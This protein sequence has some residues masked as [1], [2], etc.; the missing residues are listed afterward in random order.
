M[1]VALSIEA[2]PHP[3][4]ADDGPNKSPRLKHSPQSKSRIVQVLYWRP[5]LADDPDIESLINDIQII[6]RAK[7]DSVNR[8]QDRLEYNERTRKDFQQNVIQEKNWSEF[9]TQQDDERLA[10]VSMHAGP[11]STQSKTLANKSAEETSAG[12]ITDPPPPTKKTIF[13]KIKDWKSKGKRNRQAKRASKRKASSGNPAPKIIEMETID[14]PMASPKF[15]PTAHHHRRGS[16]QRVAA[17][18]SSTPSSKLGKSPLSPLPAPITSRPIPP[19]IKDFDIIK[20]ISKGA[21]GSVF[22]AKKR[23]TGDYYAIKFLKKSDMITK[24]QVTNVK[25]ERMILMAQTDSPFVTKLYYTFQSKDYLYLVLEYLNGGDCS[26]LVKVLGSLSLSWARNYLAEVTAG[27][28]YLHEKN[29]IHRDLKPDNLLIDQNGHLKLTDFGLSRIGFLDR[30]LRDELCEDLAPTSPAPSRSGTPPQSPSG[31][32][33]SSSSMLP[34]SKSYKQ[35][36]FSLLFDRDR[37]RRGSLASSGSGGDSSISSILN[38]EDEPKSSTGRKRTSSG[39]VAS[40]LTTPG[41]VHSDRVCSNDKVG[42]AQHAVGTPDYLAPESILGTGQDSMVDW[43]ALGVIC[44]EFLY[45]YPPFHADTPDKV[46]DNILSRRIHWHDDETP[47]ARDFMERLLTLDPD[48]RLGRNGPDEVRGHPFFAGID[49]DNLLTESPSFIPQ[50]VNEEDTDYF[51]SRGATMENVDDLQNLVMEKINRA[52][53]IIMEQNPDTISIVQEEEEEEEEEDNAISS[54]TNRDSDFGTFVYKNLPLLEKANEDAIRKIR[55]ESIV[56]LDAKGRP[57]LPAISQ[58][59]R[60]SIVDTK[61]RS[62]SQS[63]SVPSTPPLVLSPS[64]STRPS[65]ARK[66]IDS[67][68]HPLHHVEKIKNE[69]TPRRVRSISSPGNRVA[70]LSGIKANSNTLTISTAV[71]ENETSPHISTPSS[72]SFPAPHPLD[73]DEPYKAKPLDCLIADDNPISCKILET[74]L[75]LLQCRCVIV[76]NGAQAIRCAMGDKVQ[77]DFIFMDIRMPIS[78]SSLKEIYIYIYTHL[79]FFS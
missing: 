56:A 59:K 5:P 62:S 19:S 14:T 67:S 74:I 11:H 52:K 27:L 7:V 1:N 24:N 9:V 13:R 34:S 54:Q 20:P 30:R 36:Y 58:R 4:S 28:T 26:S 48:K 63:S 2:N 42:G 37:N 78:K 38:N 35:S 71:P 65:I 70:I 39:L 23:V 25:A 29:I 68:Q 69:D 76:R 40:G 31:F 61:S 77:F 75:K 66:S 41:Y 18:G 72:G 17:S 10:P 16:Q 22:L 15:H 47:E 50:P 12:A 51:D 64:N 49:W 79:F 53:E 32:S 60:S 55:Q 57:S 73:C 33:N 21:F 43:W 3:V 8:M 6:T 46:F 44:Y 45:G